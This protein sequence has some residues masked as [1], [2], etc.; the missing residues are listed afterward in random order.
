M[1]V[2]AAAVRNYMYYY[3]PLHVGGEAHRDKSRNNIDR[4]VNDTIPCKPPTYSSVGICPFYRVIGKQA[5]D[6]SLVRS[7]AIIGLL[8]VPP[9]P[10]LVIGIDTI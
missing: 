3:V 5:F 7:E 1:W 8:P 10:D 6:S 2:C 4:G 9:P